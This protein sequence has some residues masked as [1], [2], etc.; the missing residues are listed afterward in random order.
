MKICN[1]CGV[2]F[3]ESIERSRKPYFKGEIV[4][5]KEFKCPCC[6]KWVEGLD[7]IL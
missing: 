1:C 5:Q 2:V 7:V 3:S 6:K 4:T